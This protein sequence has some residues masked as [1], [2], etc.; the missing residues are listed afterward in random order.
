MIGSG[1]YRILRQ[2]ISSADS[3]AVSCVLAIFGCVLCVLS[4]LS[5][6]QHILIFLALLI[7]QT[8]VGIYFPAMGQVRQCVFPQSHISPAIINWFR[9]PLYLMCCLVLLGLHGPSY[10]YGNR[11]IYLICCLLL[12][13]AL[14]GAIGLIMRAR[15]DLPLDAKL[16]QKEISDSGDGNNETTSLEI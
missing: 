10:R 16:Q 2:K 6:S 15:K 4:S 9:L 1:I 13:L 11:P 5:S 8:A 7:Y 14:L 3:L 12:G